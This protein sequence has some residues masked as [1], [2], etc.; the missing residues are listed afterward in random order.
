MQILSRLSNSEYYDENNN[1]ELMQNVIIDELIVMSESLI[2]D[3]VNNKKHIV[4]C[5]LSVIAEWN[6]ENYDRKTIEKIVSKIYCIKLCGYGKELYLSILGQN[7][8]N[9]ITALSDY[10]KKNPSSIVWPLNP[11]I[12][13]EMCF[14]FDE[15]WLLKTVEY[16]TQ[17]LESGNNLPLYSDYLTQ[18][19]WQLTLINFMNSQNKTPIVALEQLNRFFTFI[20]Y[21]NC[22]N[23]LFIYFNEIYRELNLFSFCANNCKKKYSFGWYD[24]MKNH[25]ALSVIS[26][27]CDLSQ[28]D[29]YKVK[30]VLNFNTELLMKM[31]NYKEKFEHCKQWDIMTYNAYCIITSI[32]DI[33]ISSTQLPD[34][35]INISSTFEEIKLMISNLQPLKFRIEILKNIFACLFLRF[36]YFSKEDYKNKIKLTSHSDCSYFMQSNHKKSQFLAHRQGFICKSQLVKDILFMLKE[37]ITKLHDSFKL[38]TKKEQNNFENVDLEDFNLLENY[39]SHAIWKW[40]IMT[41]LNVENWDSISTPSLHNSLIDLSSDEEPYVST[42][43]KKKTKLKKRRSKSY[44]ENLFILSRKTKTSSMYNIFI[45]ISFYVYRLR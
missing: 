26:K 25:S 34:S 7:K 23:S 12:M 29:R 20:D 27:M 22:G 9:M 5:S 24:L 41:N 15:H 38:N 13:I 17:L 43:R 21:Q 10:E 8:Q 6:F 4:N 33:I 31:K 16:F 36:E 35:K 42:M 1:K 2:D 40:Q 28:L 3:S 45:N 14:G 19:I 30:Q 18:K 32:I 39:V 37:C 44:N 11:N